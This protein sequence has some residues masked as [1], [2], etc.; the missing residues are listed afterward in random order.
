MTIPVLSR[1]LFPSITLNSSKASN[2]LD[3]KTI[4]ITGATFGIGEAL[5]RHL[6]QYNVQLILVARTKEKLSALENESRELAAKVTTISC[7]FYSEESVTALCNQV[8]AI[9]IDYFVSNAGKSI[10]RSFEASAGRFHDYK[11]TIAVN[12]LAPVQLI[13]ALTESF[14]AAQTHIVNVGTYNVLMKAAP[15]WGAYVASKKAMHSWIESNMPEMAM[16]NITVSNLYLPLVES[17]MKDANEN[18]KDTPAMSM[19]TAVVIIIKGLLSRK[20]HF[21]PWWHVP[22]QIILFLASPFWNVVWKRR[23]GQE[24]RTIC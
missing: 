11:R 20:Y 9:H 6:F 10:M 2:K 17:R 15:K 16:M 4:L 5:V 13:S 18:Y 19:N 7:D 23:I 21:K 24:N 8:K 12:Y 14:G 3:G 22:F 1:F